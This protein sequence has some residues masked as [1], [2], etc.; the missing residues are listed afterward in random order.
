MFCMC[1]W[2][3]DWYKCKDRKN[4]FFDKN[5]SICE[6]NRDYKGYNLE[7]GKAICECNIKIKI[8]KMNI[9]HF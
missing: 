9:K 5:L 3:W 1:Y 4:E 7:F 8:P 6:S 2:R